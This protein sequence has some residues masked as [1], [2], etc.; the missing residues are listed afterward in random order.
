[1]LKINIFVFI[2]F[3]FHKVRA[4][5]GGYRPRESESFHGNWIWRSLLRLS[6]ASGV[7]IEPTLWERERD[8]KNHI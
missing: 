4:L 6:A 8:V 5:T 7:C 2:K 3:F 1:M